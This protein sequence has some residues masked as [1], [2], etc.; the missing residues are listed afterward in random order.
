MAFAMVMEEK[1][2]GKDEKKKKRKTL[3]VSNAK[4]GHYSNECT[5]EMPAE[6]DKKGTSLLIN[7][8]DSS[9]EEIEDKQYKEEEE[10]NSVTSEE[11]QTENQ[12]KDSTALDDN[13]TS[14]DKSY[15]DNSMFSDEDYGG[16]AFIQDVTCNMNNKAGI[17]DSWILLDSQSTVDVFKNKKLLKN[18]H[19]AKKALSLHC[20]A[21]I[22]TVNKI[23]DLP[24]YGTVWFYEDG[25][26]N[27]CH[28]TMSRRNTE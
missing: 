7:K 16:F 13:K 21:G 25:I 12:D 26:A 1:E 11:Y 15:E 28:L 3:H 19:D 10:N 9:D 8:D 4:K 23:G 27:I 5:E 17:P 20:N 6:S 22:A 2:K 14:D 24:G 18:I